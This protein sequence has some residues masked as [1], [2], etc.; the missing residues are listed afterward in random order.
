MASFN[1]TYA[2]TKAPNGSTIPAYIVPPDY[3]F[4]DP[5]FA[6]DFR[7]AKTFTY[8]ER[9]KLTIL[10]EM[11]N[12]FNIANLTLYSFNLDAVNANPAKQTYA[13]GQ[14]TQRA[15]QIFLS[16]GPRAAQ[17]GARFSF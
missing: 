1:A 7:L 17:V 8:K 11:F 9:Y 14:P 6:Q 12:S 2:G 15:G 16:S 10:G 4:G 3:E 13:F 5:T